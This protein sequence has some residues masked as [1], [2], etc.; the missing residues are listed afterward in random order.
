MLS[1]A[2]IFWN[3]DPKQKKICSPGFQFVV[4]DA[5]SPAEVLPSL[6][7]QTA[8]APQCSGK[9]DALRLSLFFWQGRRDPDGYS[10]LRLQ[11]AP[12]PEGL[13]RLLTLELPWEGRG[14]AEGWQNG[15]C[16]VRQTPRTTRSR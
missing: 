7:P 5:E 13:G 15:R 11:R 16:P 10:A 14:S 9:K 8:A 12:S 6:G 1:V 3:N 2:L 4:P